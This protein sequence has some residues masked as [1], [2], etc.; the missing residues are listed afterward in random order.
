MAILFTIT[1]CKKMVEVAPPVNEI[2]T[3]NVFADSSNANAAVVGIYINI[4]NSSF[5]FNLGNGTM[6]IYTGMSADDLFPTRGLPEEDEFFQNNIQAN[7]DNYI[8]FNFWQSTYKYLYQANA[9]ID[10]LN[11]STALSETMK[12]RLIGECKF[13]R[14]YLYFNLVNLYGDVPLITS[15]DFHNNAV[16]PRA[17]QADIWKLIEDDLRS[18]QTLLPENSGTS[19]IRPGKSAAAALLARV[20]LYQGRWSDCE[21]LSS[22]IIN[23]SAYGLETDLNKVFLPPSKEVLWQIRPVDPGYN[24][25]LGAQLNPTPAGKPRYGITDN[26]MTSFEIGDARKQAWIKSKIVS[27]ITYNYPFKYKLR[28]DGN[29]SPSEY[30]VTLRLAEIY[31]IR[32]EARAKQNNLTGAKD[33]LNKIRNRAGLVNTDAASQS[34]IISAI[35]RERR[36]ELFTEEAHRWFDL[37]RTGRAN[38]VLAPIKSP[39]W[40]STDELYPVPF[41]EILYNPFLTQNPGY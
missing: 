6:A 25:P 20:Y 35:E 38:S 18:A 17:M 31:L 7:P 19:R 30:F 41:N 34:D 23:N 22:L 32:A 39:N 13:I 2:V 29:T 26:L 40:K 24:T 16:L 14:A 3:A 11:N 15:I 8:N 10:G 28:F 1:S 21:L 12:N 37:K 5:D 4:M 9:C 33:D 36:T 27:S